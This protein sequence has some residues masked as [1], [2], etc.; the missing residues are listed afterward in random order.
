M[1][2]YVYC[3]MLIVFPFGGGI[4]SN[5]KF[6]RKERLF[7][8][9]ERDNDRKE[10]LFE[11]DIDRKEKLA[12]TYITVYGLFIVF[13]QIETDSKPVIRV[14][15][16]FFIFMISYCILISNLSYSTNNSST[17]SLLI[18][19]A[20]VAA[21]YSS[22]LFSFSFLMFLSQDF[23]L[24]IYRIITDYQTG[25]FILILWSS[26]FLSL[27]FSKHKPKIIQL[28]FIIVFIVFFID[29]TRD[30]LADLHSLMV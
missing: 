3:L 23:Y 13:G 10:R 15:F 16:S 24:P 30:M 27:L 4:I 26:S 21:F 9:R 22:G 20:N 14:A 11:R 12:Q 1:K 19:T 17:N 18:T 28:W 6:D 7:D 5:L 2:T 8:K 25:V 29:Q